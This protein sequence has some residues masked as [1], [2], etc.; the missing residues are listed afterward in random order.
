MIFRYGPGGA[1][2]CD[3]EIG[4]VTQRLDGHS[5]E[6]YGGR[7]LVGESMQIGAARR[8]AELLGGTLAETSLDS[9]KEAETSVEE[10]KL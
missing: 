2:I 9:F 1:L 3:E 4:D 5:A 7:F 6:Y 8:I 10:V